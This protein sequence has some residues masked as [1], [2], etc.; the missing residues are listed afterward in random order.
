LNDFSV[1]TTGYCPDKRIP[2]GPEVDQKC[3]LPKLSI[4]VV[5]HHVRGHRRREA[6]DRNVA[7]GVQVP[8]NFRN[9]IVFTQ[10]AVDRR[11]GHKGGVLEHSEERGESRMT[12]QDQRTSSQRLQEGLDPLL[13]A[14][15]VH[16]VSC[17][18]REVE[19]LLV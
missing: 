1:I 15:R 9:D 19:A 4:Q 17:H 3:P 6:N 10:V 13:V 14:S 12:Y 7:N 2:K 5:N 18:P 8:T 16:H 11:Y